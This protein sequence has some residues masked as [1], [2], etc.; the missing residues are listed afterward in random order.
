MTFRKKGSTRRDK[1]IALL[2]MIIYSTM[3]GFVLSMEGFIVHVVITMSAESAMQYVVLNCFGELKISVFKKCGYS[4]LYQYAV[5]DSV[6]RFQIA[7]YVATTWL[8]TGK[9]T[10]DLIWKALYIIVGEALVDYI[11]HFFLTK[12]NK[13]SQQFYVG[14]RLYQFKRLRILE[15]QENGL[16]VGAIEW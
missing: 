12:L 16:N 14:M 15:M 3:H 10:T 9:G 7:I 8:F 1:L 4:E 6:E 2:G 13:I 11:K 5:N